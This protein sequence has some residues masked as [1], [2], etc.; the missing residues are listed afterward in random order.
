MGVQ[1]MRLKTKLLLIVAICGISG[2]LFALEET[3]VLPVSGEFTGYLYTKGLTAGPG[4]RGKTEL[5]LMDR[6]Y[7]VEKTTDLL[8]SFD[9][10]INPG[11]TTDG[12]FYTL[13]SGNPQLD[14]RVKRF[15]P[16]SVRF[17]GGPGLVLSARPGAFFEPKSTPRTFTIEFWYYAAAV[18]DGQYLLRWDGEAW[19]AEKRINQHVSA[20][21]K[22]RGLVWTFHNFFVQPTGKGAEFK[23]LSFQLKNRRELL[24]RTW[25]HHMVRYDA[26]RGLIEYLINGVSEDTHYTTADGHESSGVYQPM[27][28]ERSHTDITIGEAATG[29]LDEFRISR[30]WVNEPQLEG[31]TEPG[32]VIFRPIEFRRIGAGSKVVRIDAP[33]RKPGGTDLVFSYMM[34]PE[35]FPPAMLLPEDKRWIKFE[36]GKPISENNT[37]LWLFVKVDFLPDGTGITSPGLQDL[38]IS[39]IPDPPPVAPSGLRAEGSDGTITLKWNKVPG[40]TLGYLIYYGVKPGR[41]FGDN[42]LE[43][44]SPINVGDVDE[45]VLH[46]LE[47][48]KL[49]YIAVA[50]YDASNNPA[51]G[52]D[53]KRSMTPE[54]RAR[55]AR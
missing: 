30:S 48:N 50:S 40:D 7:D 21:I 46:G 23:G 49:Y 15:G 31:K 2:P 4:M 32:Y 38:K 13:S 5:H 28:G 29:F 10:P 45:F 53:I 16:S 47:N 39:Y 19:L 54:V 12:G 9:R 8:L 27:V 44:P 43:G 22:N 20:A 17:D 55:P 14:T 37:G 33:T 18:G 11:L 36:P 52:M 34:L 35:R 1:G 41:Y 6:Q 24:P 25:Y 51:V 42:A 3:I 26:N